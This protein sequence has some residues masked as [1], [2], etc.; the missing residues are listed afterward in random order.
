MMI[1]EHFWVVACS[2]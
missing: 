1:P 2:L